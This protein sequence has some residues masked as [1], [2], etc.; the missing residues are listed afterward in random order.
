MKKMMVVAHR[1]ELVFQA[2]GHAR[3]AGLTAGVEMANLTYLNEEVVSASIQTLTK[4]KK[5][6]HC[7]GK[8][9]VLGYPCQECEGRGHKYRFE[10][11]NPL[12]FGV[13]VI[14]EGHHAAA[15]TYRLLIEWFVKGN[16]EIN[17]LLVTATPKRADKIGLHNVVDHVAYEMNLRAGIDQGWLCPIRQMFVTVDS[18]DL[19]RVGTNSKGDLKDGELERAFLG[20]TDEDEQK[21]L[22]AIAKPC[23]EQADGQPILVFAAGQEHAQKLTAA[24]NAY[25]GITA[26]LVIDSTD[27][28]ERKEIIRRYK[29]GATQVLVGCG[30]F[31]EGFDAPHTFLVAIARPTKSESLY[32]QMIGRGTRTLEDAL[33]GLDHA[34]AE[35]RHA[36]IAASGKSHCL[37]LDFVGNSGKHKL[38]SVADVLAG[39][40]VKPI[41]LQAALKKAMKSNEPVD[42][43]EL[44][45]KAKQ[46]R[47]KR[48]KAAAEREEERKRQRQSTTHKADRVEY[49]AHDV[50]LFNGRGFDAFSDYTP[51][52]N[53]ATQ[54][55]VNRLVKMGV[56]PE[57]AMSYSIRQAGAV[58][59]RMMKS[60]VG[61]EFRM[62]FG[63]HAGKPLKDIPKGYLHWLKENCSSANVQKHIGLMNKPAV[64]DVNAALSDTYE[65][66]PF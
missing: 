42:M 15:K 23:I 19:S 10:K 33:K 57:T 6:R 34:P 11:F 50:D 2:A 59:D 47:E 32:L 26:E 36:A 37:I 12:D 40:S 13:L 29:T 53:G 9:E 58:M 46:A 24:F 22:H 61:P 48:E 27:K 16:P 20:E 56:D 44:I 7:I 52:P 54:K 3:N 1:E 49:S 18:L 60:Q 25:D 14:D 38:V 17:L 65:E 55:Q 31:T 5:C 41:D 51:G 8:G 64:A 66:A 21:Q 4:Q 28:L 62:P 35:D 63:K 43:D 45:E 39:D 30:V